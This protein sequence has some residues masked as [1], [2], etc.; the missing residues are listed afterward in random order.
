MEDADH[1]EPITAALERVSALPARLAAARVELGSLAAADA[2][3]PL[4]KLS[5]NRGLDGASVA[6]D[7]LD[8]WRLLWGERG[9][10]HTCP[11]PRD[12]LCHHAQQETAR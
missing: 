7:H 1:V 5:W 4:G 11:R 6:V 9:Q 2:E 3:R 8:T 10:P 12:G